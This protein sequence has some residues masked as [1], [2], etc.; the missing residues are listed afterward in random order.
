[1]ALQLAHHGDEVQA[2]ARAGLDT[3]PAQPAINQGKPVR[4]QIT[5]RADDG[6]P[7][8][9]SI[10]DANADEG[11]DDLDNT[12]LS[13]ELH[14]RSV[15][16]MPVM[17]QPY[18]TDAYLPQQGSVP[19]SYHLDSD[20]SNNSEQQYSAE[21]GDDQATAIRKVD[22]TQN[23]VLK[24]PGKYYTIQ[25]LGSPQASIVS[26]FVSQNH[27]Q[28][29]ALTLSVGSDAHPWVIAL[30]GVYHSFD[31]AEEKLVQLPANMRMGGAW[32]R[33]IGDVQKVVSG[34]A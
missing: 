12:Q 15:E 6:L 11:A 2:V 1:M 23:K 5:K 4:P 7:Y 3:M 8:Q 21:S 24:L 19:R 13:M 28:R 16:I 22:L 30:Y 14:L 20:S 31:E 27:L 25:L 29:I 17:N 33:R 26:K 18:N 9:I 34:H 32:I 10:H